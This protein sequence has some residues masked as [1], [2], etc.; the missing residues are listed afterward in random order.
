MLFLKSV[1]LS[2]MLIY[3]FSLKVEARIFAQSLK[4]DGIKVEWENLYHFKTASFDST[5]VLEELN[6][7]EDFFL[8]HSNARGYYGLNQWLTLFGGGGIR[9]ISSATLDQTITNMN[10]E[11]FSVGARLKI[12]DFGGI[13]GL[14]DF[15]LKQKAYSNNFYSTGGA[16]TDD[17]VLGND[18]TSYR[19]GLS[20]T[21]SFA[22]S[23]FIQGLVN[24]VIQPSYLSDE[25]NYDV[26]YLYQGSSLQIGL[27]FTGI[28]SLKTHPYS[29]NP[30]ARPEVSRGV[31][32]LFNGVNQEE[33]VPYAELGFKIGKALITTRA[34]KTLSGVDTDEAFR[35]GLNIV[36]GIEGNDGQVNRDNVFKEYSNSAKIIKVSPRGNFFKINQGIST[37]VEKGTIVDIYQS[38]F[39]GGNI[40]VGSGVVFSVET[41]TAVVKM[42]NIYQKIPIKEGFLV[43]FK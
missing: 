40:L 23:H 2:L 15:E 14:F 42:V 20:L 31:T 4:M 25:M 21:K 19:L 3:L 32:R 36:F 41:D 11:N 1:V 22:E 38:D 10:L 24:Y 29:D 37:N 30:A 5:G 17:I 27:G 9:Y 26:Q 33:F 7:G 39:F 34:S 28:F 13:I 8:I 18:G 16:P 43:R 6:A 35:I 12:S